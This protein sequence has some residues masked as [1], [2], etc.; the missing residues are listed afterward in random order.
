MDSARWKQVDDLLQ[1]A[2]ERPP[3]QRDEFLRQACAGDTALEREVRSLLASQQE[4]GSFLE[5]PAIE[6]AAHAIASQS[7]QDRLTGQTISHYRIAEKLGSGGMG[8]VYKAEDIRLHRSVALKFLPDEIARDPHT[9]SRF[10]REAR[11]ASA[12]NHPN[13]CTIYAVEEHDG[14]P[15]I[16]MELLEGQTLKERIRKGPLAVEELLDLCIQTADALEAAH[17]KGIIHR[18]I[19]SANIFVTN[20]GNAKI[21]DFG[22]AKKV[23]PIP[24]GSGSEDLTL[25]VEDQLTTVGSALGTVAYMS[26]EQVHAKPLDSRTDLFSFGVVLYEMSTGVQPFRGPSSGIIFDLILNRAPVPPVRLN[27]DLPVELERIIDKCLEKDRNLRY[28]HALEIRTDLQRVKRDTG[29]MR[30]ITAVQPEAAES[31][32]T[33]NPPQARARPWPWIV[34]ALAV[35]FALW[36]WLRVSPPPERPLIRLLADL[37]SDGAFSSTIN[38]LT[39]SADG[40]RLVLAQSGRLWTRQLDQ[41][42]S[43][44]VTGTEGADD[45]FLSPDG[46][47]I[48]FT[49]GGELWKVSVQGGAPV[50]LCDAPGS[51]GASWGPDGH[52]VAALDR[53]G[54]LSRVPE[55][56]GTP[57]LLTHIDPKVDA[58]S[59]R[60]P[61]VLPDGA[62]VLFTAGNGVDPNRNL[63]MARVVKTG[64]TRLCGKAARGADHLARRSPGLRVSKY[65]LR[66]AHEPGPAGIDR[67]A[68][69]GGRKHRG[70][71]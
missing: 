70:L 24:G 15:I 37:G 23:A 41:A 56:G 9:L 17:S 18:D 28:Q 42:Q 21:L 58:T 10:E 1:A 6:V 32:T 16:V 62:G 4:A 19:K 57:E 14:Q 66:R 25:T 63:I 55:N 52:I 35:A 7:R 26:P 69:A 30:A 44:A 48:G 43:T 36:A 34:T 51:R 67:P 8:V 38:P 71:A 54:G 46:Q 2:L 31:I 20:R 39:I 33:A 59:H 47:W 13:I 45:P 11:A 5:S 40:R 29:S 64:Q 50:A 68:A 49:R 3:A 65:A 60:F 12:L 22:L 27:P 61:Q 53:V